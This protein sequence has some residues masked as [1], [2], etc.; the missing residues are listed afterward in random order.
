MGAIPAAVLV[1]SHAPFA[2]AASRMWGPWA[3]GAVAAGAAVS[4][5]G[6]LNGWT[7]LLGQMPR[8]AAADGL[9][10]RFFGRL[11]ARGT[12]AL[13]LVLSSVLVTLVVA[14]NYT[15]GLVAEF[16]FIIR[17]STLTALVAYLCSSL[18]LVVSSWPA[19]PRT[20]G[21]PISALF[22]VALLAF[23]YSLWAVAGIGAEALLWGSVTLLLGVPIYLAAVRRPAG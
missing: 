21:A 7:L 16:T 14:T 12:P 20:R 18:A 8:A 23:A 17:L 10:P 11:T 5:F 6:A 4:C 22:P 15:R 9:L 1:T 13:A 2:D 19:R 3:A